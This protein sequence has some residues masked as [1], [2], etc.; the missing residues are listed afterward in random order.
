MEV[1][2]FSSRCTVS[3]K[4]IMEVLRVVWRGFTKANLQIQKDSEIAGWGRSHVVVSV[5]GKVEEVGQVLLGSKHHQTSV[6][7]ILV[8]TMVTLIILIQAAYRLGQE[9]LVI[10][11]LRLYLMKRRNLCISQAYIR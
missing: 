4:W 5:L 9:T 2:F 10:Y 6:K 3:C 8:G 1:I 7:R 11:L